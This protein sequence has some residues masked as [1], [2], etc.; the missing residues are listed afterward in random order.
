MKFTSK[1][2]IRQCL[3]CLALLAPVVFQVLWDEFV[4]KK[5][6][7]MRVFYV[8]LFVSHFLDAEVVYISQGMCKKNVKQVCIIECTYI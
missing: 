4:V 7:G 8:M 5:K 3:T 1:K 2:F 6:H